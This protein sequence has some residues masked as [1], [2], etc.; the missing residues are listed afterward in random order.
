MLK[1]TRLLNITTAIQI[2]LFAMFVGQT[3][4][5]EL[6]A[7]LLLTSSHYFQIRFLFQYFRTEPTWKSIRSQ[8]CNNSSISKSIIIAVIYIVYK[9]SSIL[10]IRHS[11]GS[12]PPLIRHLS[13]PKRWTIFWKILETSPLFPILGPVMAKSVF[14]CGLP[15][16]SPKNS[17]QYFWK[18][19]DRKRFYCM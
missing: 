12:T 11:D 1:K 3:D 2:A 10:P 19:W 9:H 15:P 13:R 4:R 17:N 6:Q 16:T 8:Q 7:N 5:P 18:Q 14:G